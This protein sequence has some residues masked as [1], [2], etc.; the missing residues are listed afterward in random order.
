MRQQDTVSRSTGL[1]PEGDSD[2]NAQQHLYGEVT[3][4]SSR[5]RGRTTGPGWWP[6]TRTDWATD[7][8]SQDNFDLTCDL[9]TGQ[10][11]DSS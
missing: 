8:Q 5:Q 3:D 6:D 10:Y 4:Q 1:G 2:G 9:V 11:S 7:R